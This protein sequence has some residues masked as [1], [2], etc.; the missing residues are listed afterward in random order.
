MPFFIFV[1]PGLVHR[2]PK[3]KQ[4]NWWTSPGLMEPSFHQKEFWLLVCQLFAT[5]K[6]IR[7]VA[8][9]HLRESARASI[10]SSRAENPSKGFQ[11]WVFHLNTPHNPKFTALIKES[12]LPLNSFGCSNVLPS[13]QWKPSSPWL[14]VGSSCARRRKS[15]KFS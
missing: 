6:R 7:K 3:E 11:I 2:Y 14:S 12:L 15:L 13:S 9:E 1:S 10:P 8:S 5:N 4:I